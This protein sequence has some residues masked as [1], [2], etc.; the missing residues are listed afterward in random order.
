MP[1]PPPH[2]GRRPALVTGGSSGIGR[3]TA[4]ALAA[5][6]HPVVLGARR[7]DRCQDTAALIGERGGEAHALK[8]DLADAG[9]LSRFVAAAAEPFGPIEVLVSAAGDVLPTRAVD[10]EPDAF[11]AHVELNLLGVQR[12]CSAVVPGMVQRERGDVVLIT[13]DVVRAPRPMMS[14]YVASKWGLEGLARVMQMELER[15]GV[16]VSMVRPGPTLTGMGM[17]WEPDVTEAV[18]AEWQRWGLVRHGGYL[19]P[20]AV[21]AAVRAV[22][23][24]PRGSHWALI[25]LQPEAPLKRRPRTGPPDQKEASTT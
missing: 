19:S 4:L 9:S 6:G 8:V 5:A 15:T 7:L 2:I 24:A 16:R 12:L 11:A 17:D 13:S 1:H 10:T 20:D 21:A 18:L 23:S 25:E 22:V 14:S 3:S